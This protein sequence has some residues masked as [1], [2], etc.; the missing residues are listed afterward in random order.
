MRKLFSILFS[1][2][3][4]LLSAQ[5]QAMLKKEKIETYRIKFQQS[6][7]GTPIKTEEKKN[8]ER[9]FYDY[10]G[11]LAQSSKYNYTQDG[12][13]QPPLNT[14]YVYDAQS[15]LLSDSTDRVKSCYFYNANGMLDYS[16]QY[17][18]K[19]NLPRRIDSVVC[20]YD[21]SNRLASIT[22]YKNKGE[23]NTEEQ[24]T[25]DD[26][27]R[28]ASITYLSYSNGA[29]TPKKQ[30]QT[31][32]AYNADDLLSETKLI[33]FTS[34]SE[35]L[36]ERKVFAYDEQKRL[37]C[38]TL[39]KKVTDRMGLPISVCI[40]NTTIFTHLQIPFPLKW[41]N[42]GSIPPRNSSCKHTSLLI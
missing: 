12:K 2:S 37:L 8:L 32:F 33:R 42:T 16:T 1:F 21:Q 3:A 28:T 25:Y 27:G 11:R 31:I 40:R 7:D 38:D 15:R 34:T 6:P 19:S 36:Q 9:Y 18:Y 13:L 29:S 22:H 23:K 39:Y 14:V 5:P 41:T 17:N 26:K 35:E 20:A 10:Q 30:R 4:L 24:Y